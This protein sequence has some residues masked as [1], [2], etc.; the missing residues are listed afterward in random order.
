MHFFVMPARA[1]RALAFCL[2]L[3]SIAH[4]AHAA[5]AKRKVIIDQDT[6]GPGGSN[7]QSVLMLLQAP[8]VEVLGVTVVSGD[9]WRDEEVSHMLRLLEIAG[10]ADVPV[11][12]GAVYPLVNN[13]ARTKAWE[14]RYGALVYKGAWME[15]WPEQVGV[16]RSPYHADPSVVPPSS[17]G[18]PKLKAQAESASSFMVRS[19]R[20]YPGQVTLWCGGPLT[21]VALAAR[22]DPQFASLA[23][24]L[25]FMGGSF[26]PK[27]ADNAFANEYVHSPRRE[28]NMRFDPEAASIVLHE[29]WRQITQ[30]PI[31]PTTKTF[32][33]REFYAEIANGKA[34]FVPYVVQF[35]QQFPMWDELAA[36]VWLDPTI[37]T[38]SQQML[39]DIEAADGPAYGDTLSWP[40]GQG[41]G[42][43]EREVTVVQDIDLPRLERLT[44]DALSQPRAPARR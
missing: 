23:K 21:N 2:L 14:R 4:L 31:D 5:D 26:N 1:L 7:M 22:L 10:R 16:K 12:A 3:S 35:G 29:P 11:Y 30:V 19:V 27:A 38:R 39:V 34:P 24:A 41:P 17:L 28:F 8:D 36:A 13:Q 33:K 40:I 18:E 20:Q 15:S 37:A 32:F 25:I 6:F 42:L 9:G 43:G 44:I